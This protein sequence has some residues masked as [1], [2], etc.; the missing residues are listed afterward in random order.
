MA[1]ARSLPWT[2]ESRSPCTASRPSVIASDSL[3]DRAVQLL[4]R[5]NRAFR[6][7]LG[8]SLETKQQA[9]EALQQ[10]VVQLSRD[11]CALADTRIQRHLELMTQLPNTPP[12]DRPQQSEERDAHRARETKFVW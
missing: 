11:A 10:R 5:L 12:V 2:V 9:M 1:S 8:S 7:Q 6:Q 3:L 4:F